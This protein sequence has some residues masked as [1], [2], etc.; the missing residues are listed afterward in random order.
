MIKYIHDDASIVKGLMINSVLILKPKK[1]ESDKTRE[2]CVPWRIVSHEH[3]KRSVFLDI[4]VSHEYKIQ[5]QKEQL[6]ST[7]KSLIE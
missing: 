3:R 5:Q 6:R 2:C 1:Q 7:N 4:Q